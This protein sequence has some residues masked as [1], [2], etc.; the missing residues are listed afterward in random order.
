MA[1]IEVHNTRL[2]AFGSAIPAAGW[3][4]KFLGSPRWTAEVLPPGRYLPDAE[5]NFKPGSSDASDYGNI[6]DDPSP[7]V[8][9]HAAWAL[10]RIGSPASYAALRLAAAHETD[11]A[12][13]EEVAAALEPSAPVAAFN[14]A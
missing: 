9:G 2:R 7:L 10:G 3:E 5:G 13:A 14:Q 8:R 11:R 1:Q 4:A 6:V 12:V